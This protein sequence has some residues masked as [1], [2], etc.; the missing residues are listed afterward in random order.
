MPL[1]V[2]VDHGY[3]REICKKKKNQN[4]TQQQQQNPDFIAG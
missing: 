3:R 4:Q 1:I 2:E